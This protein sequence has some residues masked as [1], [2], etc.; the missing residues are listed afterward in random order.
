MSK[1]EVLLMVFHEAFQLELH[2]RVAIARLCE[3]MIMKLLGTVVC[4]IA[5]ACGEF[6]LTRQCVVF[7]IVIVIIIIGIIIIIIISIIIIVKCVGSDGFC[8]VGLC[9]RCGRCAEALDM[10]R[11]R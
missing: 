8:C 11:Q 5:N 7:V 2:Q 3:A 6:E 1:L 4:L 10:R 9:R